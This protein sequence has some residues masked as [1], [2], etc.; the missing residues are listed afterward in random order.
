MDDLLREIREQGFLVNNLYQVD[1]GYWR[2]N[3]RNKSNLFTAFATGCTMAEA[4]ENS[5]IIMSEAVYCAQPEETKHSAKIE[6]GLLQQLGLAPKPLRR[7][8]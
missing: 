3:L 1:S 5:M 6:M 2:C 8:I 7:R 4:L